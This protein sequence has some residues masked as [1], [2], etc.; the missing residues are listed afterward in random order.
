MGAGTNKGKKPSKLDLYY[1]N[2]WKSNFHSDFSFGFLLSHLILLYI[3][4]CT[5]LD[6]TH[7]SSKRK[8]QN[9]WILGGVFSQKDLKRDTPPHPNVKFTH[10]SPNHITL[11]T[12]HTN[13]HWN[14]CCRSALTWSPTTSTEETTLTAP[15]MTLAEITSIGYIS[16]G[17]FI[18]LKSHLKRDLNCISGRV[19]LWV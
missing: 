16:L 18:L 4:F 19:D 15:Y 7:F 13:G 12:M 2:F 14:G 10:T 3:M 17:G 1:H 6:G 9:P 11:L 8:F 5:V